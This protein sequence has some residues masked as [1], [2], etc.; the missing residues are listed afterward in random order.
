VRATTAWPTG[1]TKNPEIG[2]ELTVSR[3]L[4]D[5]AIRLALSPEALSP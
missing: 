5:L 4:E 2:D 1:P 3:A